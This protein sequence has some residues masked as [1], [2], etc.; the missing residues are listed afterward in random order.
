MI[1]S[2]MFKNKLMKF[3]KGVD[4]SNSFTSE[5]IVKTTFVGIEIMVFNMLSFFSILTFLDLLT[6]F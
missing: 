2:G 5:K 3:I 4:R 6:I 1:L